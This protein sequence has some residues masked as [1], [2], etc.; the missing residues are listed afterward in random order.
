[1]GLNHNSIMPP[2]AAQDFLR[3]AYD[4]CHV[5][6]IDTNTLRSFDSIGNLGPSNPRDFTFEGT[7]YFAGDGLRLA[8][9]N[10]Y[11][12]NFGWY[13]NMTTSFWMKTT[14]SSGYFY[15]ENNRPTGG[16]ARIYSYLNAG[17]FVFQLWDNSNY[18][19]TGNG[20]T[21]CNQQ[22]FSTTTVNN[23]EW[24][25]IT[26]VWTNNDSYN[27]GSNASGGYVYVNG[28]QEAFNPFV[29]N[30]GSYQLWNLGGTGGCLGTSQQD[31]WLGPI[32]GY[33]TA[34]TTSQIQYNYNLY[35]NRYRP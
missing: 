1:M 30:D 35:K 28:V 21:D 16:C 19:A 24:H 14:S 32:H 8:G 25:Y 4:P 18:N 27:G 31:C 13:G 11:T 34:L 20:Y 7:V 33:N 23:N 10:L 26:C 22:I 15:T 5:E 2:L 12:S 3:V 6:S 17:R 29:G 9:G